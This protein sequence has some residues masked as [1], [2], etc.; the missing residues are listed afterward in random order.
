VNCSGFEGG[1]EG[2]EEDEVELEARRGV[3]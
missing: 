1:V 3:A 2:V